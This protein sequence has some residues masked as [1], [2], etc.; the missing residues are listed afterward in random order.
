MLPAKTQAWLDRGVISA[1][2]RREREEAMVRGCSLRNAMGV[3]VALRKPVAGVGRLRKNV[4]IMASF[5]NEPA[6]FKPKDGRVHGGNV[7]GWRDAR[8]DTLRLPC[9]AAAS[10]MGRADSNAAG[11][12]LA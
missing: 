9:V 11:P 1:T 6:A 3:I 7:S 2:L 4:S 5:S 12:A 10:D 8:R